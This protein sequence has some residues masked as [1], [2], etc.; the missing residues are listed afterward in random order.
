MSTLISLSLSIRL[1]LLMTKRKHTPRASPPHPHR[2]ILRL[3]QSSQ[4]RT[5]HT[6]RPEG[7]CTIERPKHLPNRSEHMVR[8][9]HHVIVD[10]YTSDVI[11][12]PI[13]AHLRYG[14]AFGVDKDFPIESTEVSKINTFYCTTL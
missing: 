6:G 8:H 7:S 4:S 5:D 12:P 3:S 1:R 13:G 9:K 11:L 2:S 14:G 10:E